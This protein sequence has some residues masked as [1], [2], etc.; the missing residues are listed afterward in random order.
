MYAVTVVKAS[1]QS[2]GLDG[3]ARAALGAKTTGVSSGPYGL[4]IWLVDDVPSPVDLQMAEDVLAGHNSLI[5]TQDKETITA[6]GE[7][8]ATVQV[9]L[10]DPEFDYTVWLDGEKFAEGYDSV[11]GGQAVVEL[12]STMAGT[13]LIEIRRRQGDYASGYST[14]VAEE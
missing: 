7:D 13:F 14:V 11:V 8:V 1:T 2:A 3:A 5:L 6:D 12:T 10:A 4:T 9:A